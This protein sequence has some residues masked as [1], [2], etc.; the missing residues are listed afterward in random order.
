MHLGLKQVQETGKGGEGEGGT[1]QEGVWW[2]QV[3]DQLCSCSVRVHACM[4]VHLLYMC[5]FVC[6]CMRVCVSRESLHSLC[7]HCGRMVRVRFFLSGGILSCSAWNFSMRWRRI[8]LDV[9]R[10]RVRPNT[11]VVSYF[12]RDSH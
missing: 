10:R 3:C 7:P 4:H 6:V 5:A 12:G 9:E 8:T 1:R 11:L 2:R